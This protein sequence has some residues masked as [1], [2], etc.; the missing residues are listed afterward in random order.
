MKRLDE[1]DLW[2]V[3]PTIDPEAPVFDTSPIARESDDRPPEPEPTPPP[4]PFDQAAWLADLYKEFHD[5]AK[6][7]AATRD[8]PRIYDGV[9]TIRDPIL[10]AKIDLFIRVHGIL[11]IPTGFVVTKYGSEAVQAYNG[12]ARDDYRKYIGRADKGTS[13]FRAAQAIR[14]FAYADGLSVVGGQMSIEDELHEHHCQNPL[15]LKSLEGRRPQTRYCDDKCSKADRRRLAVLDR[16]AASGAQNAVRVSSPSI[17]AD[18]PSKINDFDAAK[19]SKTDSCNTIEQMAHPTRIG[20]LQYEAETALCCILDILNGR[21]KASRGAADLDLN[22]IAWQPLPQDSDRVL[23]AGRRLADLLARG[24][25][26]ALLAKLLPNYWPI[27]G[28]PIYPGMRP[29]RVGEIPRGVRTSPA[30]WELI[31]EMKKVGVASIIV[32]C[33]LGFVDDGSRR[34]I[35][36]RIVIR[37]GRVKIGN[38]PN[39]SAVLNKL[40]VA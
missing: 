28:E 36:E 13:S 16:I 32:D 7:A 9:T 38:Y 6:L 30:G 29:F 39:S 1:N 22:D 5:P 23:A 18:L 25:L 26:K 2:P 21:T 8:F 34:E 37:D 35:H 27:A 10:A 11:K 31:R 24:R 14:K 15:C 17:V 3:E 33:G 19:G 4:K 12:Q 40:A 20:Q